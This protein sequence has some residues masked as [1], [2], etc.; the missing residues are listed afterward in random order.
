MAIETSVSRMHI[1]RTIGLA[2]LC[3]VFGLWGLYDYMIAIPNQAREA[4]LKQVISLVQQA[5][6]S[7][8]AELRN[9]SIA[10]IDVEVQ[11]LKDKLQAAASSLSQ[12]T[13]DRPVTPPPKTSQSTPHS[14]PCVTL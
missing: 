8:D 11:Y 12:E 14:S 13:D 3:L 10:A 6:T 2:V 7:Q 5:L 1:G 9:E 4:Q